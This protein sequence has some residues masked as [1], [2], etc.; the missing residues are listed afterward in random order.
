[1]VF[2]G[3]ARRPKCLAAAVGRSGRRGLLAEPPLRRSYRVIVVPAPPL[4]RRALRVALRRVFPLLLTPKR[5]HVEVTP[6]GHERLVAAVVDEVGAENPVA[7]R[8]GH[9]DERG[10]AMPLVDAE[11]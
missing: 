8:I 5:G 7:S 2:G 10:R 3:L 9:A 1:M 6:R 4:K 11:V